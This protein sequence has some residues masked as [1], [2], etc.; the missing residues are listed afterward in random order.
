MPSKR[1]AYFAGWQDSIEG[2]VTEPP[3]HYSAAARQAWAAGYA[4]QRFQDSVDRAGVYTA[5][6]WESPDTSH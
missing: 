4:Q 6:L 2:A 1:D 3:A 5:L